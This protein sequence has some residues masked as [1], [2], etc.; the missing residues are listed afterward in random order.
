MLCRSFLPAVTRGVTITNLRDASD[1]A[2][3]IRNILGLLKTETLNSTWSL[4][5]I[6]AI[7]AKRD[8]IH[9]LSDKSIPVSGEILL[10][11]VSGID[12]TIEGTFNAFRA[13]GKTPWLIIRAVDGTAIDIE[14]LDDAVLNKIRYSFRNVSDLPE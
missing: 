2:I 12:Q 6:E 9:R 8:E 14:T 3:D 5:Q 11:M 13:G 7:G 1:V 10:Q 4:T